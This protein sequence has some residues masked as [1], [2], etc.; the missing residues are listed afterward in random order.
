MRFIKIDDLAANALIELLDARDVRQVSLSLLQEYADAVIKKITTKNKDEIIEI[1]RRSNDMVYLRDY[2]VYFDVNDKDGIIS[3]R[4]GVEKEDLYWAFRLSLS[5][6]WIVAFHE[7]AK[8]V[9]TDE[10]ISSSNIA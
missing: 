10:K 1:Y 4:D 2:T 7:A 5:I 3:L 6:D 9:F 8:E